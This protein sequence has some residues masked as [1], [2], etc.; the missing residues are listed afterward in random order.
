V[1]LSSSEVDAKHHLCDLVVPKLHLTEVSA[2][3]VAC[4][5]DASVINIEDPEVTRRSS[6]VELVGSWSPS[7]EVVDVTVEGCRVTPVVRVFPA[8]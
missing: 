2:C 7:T 3:V 5:L 8:E 4:D 1:S 6:S